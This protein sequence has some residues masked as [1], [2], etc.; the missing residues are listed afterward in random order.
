MPDVGLGSAVIGAA[1]SIF[2]G[3]NDSTMEQNTVTEP[4]G[5]AQPYLKTVLSEGQRLYDAGAEDYPGPT[6]A[7]M[8]P[9][10]SGGLEQNLNYSQGLMP[11]QIGQAQGSW[12]NALN[13][14]DVVNNPYVMNQ[15]MANTGLLNRNLNENLLP[16]IQ[17]N[18]TQ[19][20]QSGS[21]RHG[22]AQ[23]IAL[24][25]TQEAAA[26][27]AAATMNQAYGQGL[28]ARTNAMQMSPQMLGLGMLP[29]MQQQNFGNALNNEAQKYINEMMTRHQYDQDMPWDMLSRLQNVSTS[30]GG[31][32]GT[33]SSTS[34]NPNQQNPFISG[35]GG[36]MMGYDL[37]NTLF[38]S[39]PAPVYSPLD[40]SNLA[41]NSSYGWPSP[42]G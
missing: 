4:W 22:V 12:Q 40:A 35:L 3:N 27:Q 10:Q 1:G 39:N 14:P 11:N 13:S 9:W 6:F 8:N 28:G 41:T 31:M 38:G 33:A 18:A 23:G 37:G 5:P 32:G 42:V 16:L 7:P 19:A 29:G 21:S 17:D 20:G 36:G 2:G 24:R 15:V 30:T 25:G 26:R 34:P